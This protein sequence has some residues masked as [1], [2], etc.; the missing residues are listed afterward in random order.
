MSKETSVYRGH[1][2]TLAFLREKLQETT[3]AKAKQHIL[4][5]IDAETD[6]QA[7]GELIEHLKTNAVKALLSRASLS[8]ITH[9]QFNLEAA[10]ARRKNGCA[11]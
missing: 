11:S 4:S 2:D 1:L 8:F 6:I 7:V 9:H 10:F 3:D 5:M